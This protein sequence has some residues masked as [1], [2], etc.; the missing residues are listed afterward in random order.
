LANLSGANLNGADVT[1]AGAL[2]GVTYS[3]TTCPDGTD[4]DNDDGTCVGHGVP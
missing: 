1:G 4:S 2:L 3:N